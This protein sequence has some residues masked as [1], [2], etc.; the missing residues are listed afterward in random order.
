M[1]HI[2]NSEKDNLIAA[3]ISGKISKEEVQEIHSLIH[4]IINKNKK[5][6]FYFELDD[7]HGY[8]LEG[9]WADLKVDVA[10]LSDYGNMAIVGEEKWQEWAVKASDLFTGSEVKY[11][12][13]KDKEA[14]K[15]W[16]GL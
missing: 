15:N 5:V 12:D 14:A 16:I 7:F 3:K 8:E 6:G 9:L 4:K 11:F 2:L 1:I 10:H 13:L